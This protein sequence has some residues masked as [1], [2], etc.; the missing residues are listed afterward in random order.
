MTSD[1]RQILGKAMKAMPDQS[2]DHGEDVGLLGEGVGRETIKAAMAR[3]ATGLEG[4]VS[5]EI[6]PKQNR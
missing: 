2:P 5:K 6:N 1:P 3:N 4:N